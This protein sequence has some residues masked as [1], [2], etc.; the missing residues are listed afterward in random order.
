[1]EYFLEEFVITFDFDY[2]IEVV[3][4]DFAFLVDA[5]ILYIAYNHD[6]ILIE[7][8]LHLDLFVLLVFLLIFEFEDLVFFSL[9]KY[10]YLEVVVFFVYFVVVV[11]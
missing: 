9:L 2:S 7:D 3:I 4:E 5:Y 6:Q 1:M 11:I 10:L 8:F